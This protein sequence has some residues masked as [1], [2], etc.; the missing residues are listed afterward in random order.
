MSNIILLLYLV[1]YLCS[2]SNYFC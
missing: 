1:C 2:I